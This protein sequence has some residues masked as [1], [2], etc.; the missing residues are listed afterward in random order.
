MVSVLSSSAI[1]RLFELRLGHTSVKLVYAVLRSKSKD[2][3]ALNQNNTF[4]SGATC[5]PAGRCFS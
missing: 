1:D 5:L 3:L 4:P 2:W